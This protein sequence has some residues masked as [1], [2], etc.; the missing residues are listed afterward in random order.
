MLLVHLAVLFFGFPGVI[1]KVLPLNPIQLTWTRV[2]LASLG[3]L[4]VLIIQQERLLV[5][6]L[7]SVLLLIASGIL[8]AFH[9]TAFFQSVRIST[10]AVGLLSYSTFPIFTIFLEPWLLR[11]RFQKSYLLFALACFLGVAMMVPEFSL[12]NRIF[13]GVIWGV[14]SG[15]AFA[16][17]A[18]I[19]RI[20][21][22][23]HSSLVL[24][25]Y[26]N[27]LAMICLLPLFL[28][29]PFNPAP[30]AGNISLI[31][32]LGLVCTAGAHTMF[33]RGLRF[34][35]ARLTSLIS[36][37]EPVYGIIFGYIF[38]REIPEVR[39]LFGGFLILSSVV[40][41]SW[42]SLDSTS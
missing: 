26:Q 1:G 13:V 11:I 23:R 34:I 17:L 18:I 16:F 14:L 21:S 37:L 38:L 22:P 29:R 32:F 19:N 35:E 15:L 4:T 36:S 7:R 10:V 6:S 25:F 8:L 39:T 28:S 33:I 9:W 42:K 40:L 2:F 24:A 3:L 27:T 30:G 31:L 41:L 20:L 12:S 5:S